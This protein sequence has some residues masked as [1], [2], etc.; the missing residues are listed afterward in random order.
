[1]SLGPQVW[2]GGYP[3]MTEQSGIAVPLGAEPRLGGA[4]EVVPSGGNSGFLNLCV[5][6]LRL[7]MAQTVTIFC[8]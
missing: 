2:F 7:V 8:E 1:V 6:V 5:L 3:L 4:K